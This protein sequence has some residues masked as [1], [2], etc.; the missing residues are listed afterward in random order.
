MYVCTAI[1]AQ[2]GLYVILY[3]DPAGIDTTYIRV[4]ESVEQ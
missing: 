3:Q 4:R 2:I 1:P